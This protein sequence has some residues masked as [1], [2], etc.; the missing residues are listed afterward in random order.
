VASFFSTFALI[1]ATVSCAAMTEASG[2]AS[3]TGFRLK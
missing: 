2:K 3:R 1:A